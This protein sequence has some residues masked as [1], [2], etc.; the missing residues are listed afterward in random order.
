MSKTFEDIQDESLKE[1][2]SHF[3]EE[4]TTSPK[5]TQ[6]KNA[7]SAL[8]NHIDIEENILIDTI[9]QGKESY[10]SFADISSQVIEKRQSMNIDWTIYNPLKYDSEYIKSW[11]LL[12]PTTISEYES[13]K[14]L[15]EEIQD[16]IHYYVDIPE[17]FEVI[18]AYYI[19]MTYFFSQFTEVPYL[20]VIGDYGS[21]K[22]RFLKAVGGLCYQPIMANWW[23]STAALFRVIDIVQGTL[24]FDEADIKASDT[25]ND[26]VK[27]LN[28]WF[29]KGL[30]IMR[31]DGEKFEPK[32]YRVFWPKIIWSR[33]S[34]SDIALE[35]RCISF[36]M[37]RTERNDIPVN[38]DSTFEEKSLQLRNKLLRYRYDNW[39]K[40]ELSNERIE[41]LE[42]RLNQIINPILSVCSDEDDRTVIILNSFNFQEELLKDRF[43]SLEWRIFKA[44]K[45]LSERN[46]EL[47]Y[48]MILNFIQDEFKI[49]HRRLWA[50]LKAH[51]IQVRRKNTGFVFNIVENNV[52][53]KKY[54]KQYGVSF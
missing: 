33:E 25:T 28:N 45:S 46:E 35:S 49:T 41:D 2:D 13:K 51:Q 42:S 7:S 16:F 20:R 3:K 47:E 44:I 4:T 15:L 29:Q 9:I 1:L 32:S 5:N 22:S 23:I 37:R 19:F 53:L 30:P 21:G 54:Y 27:I 31:A 36:V 52:I 38:L 39:N 40:I 18:S 17:E 6:T 50:I 8:I 48:K 14:K 43:L 34:F 12:F 24:V 11:M 10:F 26:M